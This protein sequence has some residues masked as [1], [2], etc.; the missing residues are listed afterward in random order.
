MPERI[1]PLLTER[2]GIKGSFL[3][4]QLNESKFKLQTFLFSENLLMR[5]KSP[6]YTDARK[7][8]P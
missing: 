6:F 1:S 3:Y 7:L 4:Y 2:W 5:A 8:E